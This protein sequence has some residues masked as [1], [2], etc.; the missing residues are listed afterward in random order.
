MR[1]LLPLLLL[2]LAGCSLVP[3]P[4]PSISTD[5]P[6]AVM[7]PYTVHQYVGS[8][9]TQLS[10]INEPFKST[11]SIAVSSFYLA[12]ALDTQ[13][14]QGQG[15]GLSQQIQES[16]ITQFTQLGYNTLEYRLEGQLNLSTNGDAVLSRNID[17]LKQSQNID[18]MI[19]GTLTRQEHAYIVNARMVNMRTNQIV[20]AGSTEIPI[21][22][23][24]GSEKIQQR[25]DY[26]YRSEY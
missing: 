3:E 13:L 19:T 5:A 16:L 10:H 11:A 24:W 25:G 9:S 1:L 12:N 23:M 6:K 18:F 26:L 2:N 20:S 22:V 14:A 7:A 8:L 4:A 21:N 15:I 17:K